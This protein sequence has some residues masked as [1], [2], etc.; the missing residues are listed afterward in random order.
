MKQEPSFAVEAAAICGVSALRLGR[1]EDAVRA[2]R[3]ASEASPLSPSLWLALAEASIALGAEIEASK[4]LE[5]AARAGAPSLEL[6]ELCGA[7]RRSRR[8]LPTSNA[9]GAAG[10][11]EEVTPGQWEASI[12]GLLR[13]IMPRSA[14][15]LLVEP[16]A[17]A[18]V[19][20]VR[21][22]TARVAAQCLDADATVEAYS[23][24]VQDDVGYAEEA[25]VS[26]L[27]VGAFEAAE[28]CA[29]LE[30]RRTG[31]PICHARLATYRGDFE[32]AQRHVV[33]IAN[34]AVRRSVEAALALARGRL[35]EAAERLT[36]APRTP[37]EHIM[38]LDLLTRLGRVEDVTRHFEEV[39]SSAVAAC[40]A[41]PLVLLACRSMSENMRNED[42]ELFASLEADFPDLAGADDPGSFCR[43]AIDSL[44]GNWTSR[45]TRLSAPGK[46]GVQAIRRPV[47]ERAAALRGALRA[48]PVTKVLALHDDL[49]SEYG[50]HPLIETY[51]SEVNLWR[52]DM[53]AA[54]AGFK[55]ALEHDKR[56]R[57]AY[58]GLATCQLLQGAPE[59]AVQTFEEQ[60][61]WLVPTRNVLSCMAEVHLR[62]GRLVE[63]EATYR[64]ALAAFST[65]VS[66]WS[67]IGLVGAKRSA[68][69]LVDEAHEHMRVL[70]PTFYAQWQREAA[71]LDA[72]AGFEHALRMMR[73]NRSSSFV[74]WWTSDGVFHG[75]DVP[76]LT[77]SAVTLP[78]TAR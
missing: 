73:G 20:Q 26:L 55:R 27:G 46:L 44:S 2:L 11:G 17:S 4:A 15:L 59:L 54:E 65:R 51:R 57:W 33:R 6:E 75:E 61:R 74:T 23:A 13:A 28:A 16:P 70:A 71:H 25:F 63:A 67:G 29:E 38:Y 45:A 47:R 31:Q 5:A 18:S 24:L 36:E 34:R 66:A 22:L 52:G 78:N 77:D 50:R 43:A 48:V 14:R 60:G 72:E 42:L 19:D 40:A 7:L 41:A 10:R 9:W 39:D 68:A 53:V 58:I 30:E 21:L 8:E 69:A 64:E 12:M 1:H 62:L 35:A 37:I 56:T 76:A 49:E 3:F 32:A